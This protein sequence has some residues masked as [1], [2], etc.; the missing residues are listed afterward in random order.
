M[1]LTKKDKKH[2]EKQV[3]KLSF[4]I[5]EEASEYMR[6]YK[7]AYYEEVINMCKERIEAIDIL[8]EHLKNISNTLP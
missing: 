2:I 5:M 1:E 8:Q 4:R 3:S 7:K 6:L